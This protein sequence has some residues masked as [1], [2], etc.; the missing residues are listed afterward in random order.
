MVALALFGSSPYRNLKAFGS[1]AEE[2]LRVERLLL[3]LKWSLGSIPLLRVTRPALVLYSL[4]ALFM[5]RA[6][7]HHDY[8]VPR[9][10]EPSCHLDDMD[11][12]SRDLSAAGFSQIDLVPSHFYEAVSGSV[13]IEL[14]DA[15]L[16]ID[17]FEFF[18]DGTH[19]R[20]IILQKGNVVM[21][22]KNTGEAIGSLECLSQLNLSSPNVE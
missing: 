7:H 12:F 11:P 20:R 8:F 16:P 17:T 9:P 3:D 4:L 19:G 18:L 13:A 6:S 15:S 10:M 14:N 1:F 21:I 5:R 22:A 2:R